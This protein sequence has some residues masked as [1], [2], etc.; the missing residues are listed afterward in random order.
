MTGHTVNRAFKASGA[1]SVF[2]ASLTLGLSMVLAVGLAPSSASA[3]TRLTAPAADATLSGAQIPADAV[4]AD[5]R[6]DGSVNVAVNKS[7]VVTAPRRFREL[8]VGSSAI[9][10]VVPLSRTQFYVLG[11]EVGT[12]NIVLS[13]GAGNVL[14][15]IDVHVGFDVDA[16]KRK[17]YEVAPQNAIEV[18]SSQGGLVLSGSVDDAGTAATIATIAEGYAPGRVANMMTVKGGQQVMLQVRFA[19]VQRSV[20]KDIGVSTDLIT[21]LDDIGIA[22]IGDDLNPFSFASGG[23]FVTGGNFALDILVDALEQKGYVRTLAEPNL[24][25]LSG[26]TASF[27]AGGEFPVP[28]ANNIGGAGVAGGV[29]QITVQFR[30]FGIGLAFTPTVLGK[31]TIN[32]ELNAEVSAI[33]PTISVNAGLVDVPGL[34]VRRAQT[35]VEMLDG[36]SFAIAGLIEDDLQENIRQVPWLGSVPI[37]GALARSSDF[38]RRQT[39]LVVIITA[40]LVQPVSSKTAL[41]DPTDTILPPREFDF[42]FFG[43]GERLAIDPVGGGVDGQY[44]YEQP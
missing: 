7:Q 24:I 23:A 12:T 6:A 16:L 35:T 15:V 31:D 28:I 40:R 2:A 33:D 21:G 30:Q 36:Q 41:G 4:R 27:L 42:F 22:S 39:E 37:L 1:R 20:L 11:R 13:D 34:A 18:R 32:L 8:T 29:G 26:D 3:Q 25:A 10:D 38:E 14:D 17:V 43:K 19:E 9:A 44:G 5:I